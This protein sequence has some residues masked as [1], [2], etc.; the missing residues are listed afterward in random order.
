MAGKHEAF[1][2]RIGGG[3]STVCNVKANALPLYFLLQKLIDFQ[4]NEYC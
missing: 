2:V 3:E 4:T 1:L